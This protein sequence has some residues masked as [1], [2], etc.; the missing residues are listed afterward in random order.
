MIIKNY[1]LFINESKEDIIDT[2][3][4][5]RKYNITN[6]IINEDGSVDVDGNVILNDIGLTK[7]PLRFRNV[8]G[9]FDCYSNTLTSLQG[10]PKSV[11]GYIDCSY[12]NIK[13]FQGC[14]ESIG[15][16]FYCV[17][18]PIEEIYN[19]FVDKSKIDL[20]NDFDIIRDDNTIIKDRL[21]AFLNEIGKEDQIKNIDEIKNYKLI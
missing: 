6:Y 3:A 21:I 4:I 1:Q 19:L 14:S 17:N 12:N 11:G 18:N 10:S 7:L 15:E 9:S 8:S 2:H 13:T 20:F 5:C 16:Y